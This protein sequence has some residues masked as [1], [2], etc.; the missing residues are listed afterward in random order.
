MA[1]SQKKRRSRQRR[2]DRRDK[3]CQ[4]ID[5]C[6]LANEFE[7]LPLAL[8]RNL[9]RFPHA[10]L[11]VDVS[12]SVRQN[13]EV[14]QLKR[15]INDSIRSIRL[16]TNLGRETIRAKDMIELS[17]VLVSFM[18]WV[19][20]PEGQ[21][22]CGQAERHFAKA[23]E[24]KVTD[25]PLDEAFNL[26]EETALIYLTCSSRIDGSTYWARLEMRG[27]GF[28]PEIVL[29]VKEVS[30]ETVLIEIDGKARPCVRCL[31]SRGF[32]DEPKPVV[33][34][35]SLF[36]QNQESSSYPVYIQRHAL[37]RLRER[38][39]L[40]EPAM[41]GVTHQLVAMSLVTPTI[42]RNSRGDYL[43]KIGRAEAFLGYFPASLVEDKVVL[44][45]FLSPTMQGAPEAE[46]LRK[47]LGL[48][49]YDIEYL[50]LD[51]PFTLM[52]GDLKNDERFV[53]IFEK[54]GL[55]GFIAFSK[56][57]VGTDTE[58]RVADRIREYIGEDRLDRAGTKSFFSREGLRHR[59][60]P[61]GFSFRDK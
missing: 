18:N 27:G 3:F 16:D 29:E 8:Q 32:E 47:E 12:D 15:Q 22:L 41:L 31:A 56:S 38:F 61:P 52:F 9:F 42:T 48:C 2:Q 36:T 51:D 50:N 7:Q 24:T 11:T 30:L 40:E 26:I 28:V 37:D 17:A 14:L 44:R 5:A 19:D 60:L 35:T 45:T 39:H 20:S 49:R 53:R 4:F 34:E 10:Q 46:A 59:L 23:V 54:C 13:P 6:G 58:L 57:L 21:D 33:W 1:S 25:G 43:V 55:G